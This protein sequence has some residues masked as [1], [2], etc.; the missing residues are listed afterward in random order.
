MSIY[1]LSNTAFIQPARTEL[2]DREGQI[3][4]QSQMHDFVFKIA[5]YLDNKKQKNNLLTHYKRHLYVNNHFQTA[6]QAQMSR[7]QR[8]WEAQGKLSHNDK[9]LI[10]IKL[11]ESIEF[12][13]AGFA[14]RVQDTLYVLE[15]DLSVYHC[16]QAMR[17][18][19]VQQIS[20]RYTNEVHARNR[21]FVLAHRLKL[22]VHANLSDEYTGN[23]PDSTILKA[24]SVHFP[25]KYQS[26]A[27]FQEV[28]ADISAIL[29]QHYDYKGLLKEDA[30]PFEIYNKWQ[31]VLQLYFGIQETIALQDL[32]L[33]DTNFQVQD[34][35]W[36][37]LRSFI[38]QFLDAY[39]FD[40]PQPVSSAF[41]SW[42]NPEITLESLRFQPMLRASQANHYL[43]QPK[44]LNYLLETAS[45]T[46]R[47]KALFK[48]YLIFR[49]ESSTVLRQSFND[50]ERLSCL[51]SYS[52]A[53][54]VSLCR[55]GIGNLIGVY[56]EI[57][58]ERALEQRKHFI[59]LY[60]ASLTHPLKLNHLII[61]KKEEQSE[62]Y[63]E[64]HLRIEEHF[65]RHKTAYMSWL[66]QHLTPTCKKN[67]SFMR[68]A[69]DIFLCLNEEEKRTFIQFDFGSNFNLLMLAIA[70]KSPATHVLI[71]E[72]W[73][74]NIL[75]DLLQQRSSNQGLNAL[76]MASINY[77]QS[78]YAYLLTQCQH[79]SEDVL[80][81]IL[82]AN[83]TNNGF[84]IL[85]LT[86]LEQPHLMKKLKLLLERLPV[87]TLAALHRQQVRQEK[88]V[89]MLAIEKRS[90]SISAIYQ[91]LSMLDTSAL[92][93][94]MKQRDQNNHNIIHYLWLYR[95]WD[96]FHLLRLFVP[97]PL[98]D[99]KEIFRDTKRSIHHA[100]PTEARYVMKQGM[101]ALL[102]E[103]KTK[104]Q[105]TLKE[106]GDLYFF[107]MPK[108]Q[109]D[110]DNLLKAMIIK[111]DLFRYADKLPHHFK[112]IKDLKTLAKIENRQERKQFC[113]I[114]KQ[115]DVYL[116]LKL[117]YRLEN[118]EEHLEIKVQ[119]ADKSQLF[120][121]P[122]VCI[123]KQLRKKAIV[124]QLID[125]IKNDRVLE[126]SA[127]EKAFIHQSGINK[128]VADNPAYMNIIASLMDDVMDK[129]EYD[130][131]DICSRH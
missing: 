58:S 18:F 109:N 95:A 112:H 111:P 48:S 65:N 124:Q 17:H 92:T 117:C 72:A 64:M 1:A 91:C 120:F 42:F 7:L 60:M 35:N 43:I 129:P 74:L 6:L 86:L 21:F 123:E 110:I 27:I 20:V 119:N 3:L 85:F 16:L 51:K 32:L 106:N 131:A 37:K 4:S 128:V 76:M 38:W 73:R 44:Y 2:V 84:N 59:E 29:K 61:F 107:I 87:K 116:K 13:T 79:L 31:H 53:L 126:M 56:D 10:A 100:I 113:R 130:A 12:C 118:Y 105:K 46:F 28:V 98:E 93:D 41:L 101:T 94:I 24:L 122:K 81:E 66:K 70:F 104:I 11:S 26:L 121:K 88:T 62:H 34:I 15:K 89:Y 33:F 40:L 90:I 77:S 82:T 50:A 19:L 108:F 49:D 22:G 5:E 67:P 115:S 55:S 68:T 125:S 83:C 47:A 80:G 45:D 39:V 97:M 78:I 23:I 96:F 69:I 103:N 99:R 75:P 71:K 14:D 30:Y 8:H 114:F 52:E 63:S 57:I 54:L 127:E 102:S 36:P 9:T 25:E